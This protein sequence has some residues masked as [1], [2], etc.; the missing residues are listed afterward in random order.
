MILLR[1]AGFFVGIILFGNYIFPHFVHIFKSRN[2]KAFT[3]LIILALFFSLFAEQMG[4]SFMLGAFFAGVFF[5]EQIADKQNFQKIEDRVFSVAFSFLGPLFFVSL[6][7]HF[8]FSVFYDFKDVT[9]L[10]ALI[11]M[12]TFSKIVGAGIM[13][14]Y[15]CK[16]SIYE[17]TA[18]GIA[19]N[20]RAEI[21]FAV[22]LLA[23]NNEFMSKEAFSAL[24]GTIFF[25]NLITPLL[26][27]WCILII[28]KRGEFYRL[29][30][31]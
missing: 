7:F 18:I 20:G 16:F 14:R 30:E 12:A 21:A 13:A 27:K 10:V 11:F 9:F 31:A 25:L 23:L 2:K 29:K 8:D 3:F 5:H 15:F 17:S 24:I 1:L 19:M 22:A 26:L 28:K 4:L 6:G